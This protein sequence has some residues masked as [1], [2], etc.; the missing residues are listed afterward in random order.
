M[1]Y[2]TSVALIFLLLFAL[3]LQAQVSWN[4]RAGMTYSN[5]SYERD[6]NKANTES[7]PGVS[8]GLGVNLPIWGALSLEP[9]IQYVKRGFRAPGEGQ[10]GWGTKF[11]AR[12]SYLELPIGAV[13]SPQVGPG[14]LH[15]A[16]GPYIGYGMG[17]KWDSDGM[18]IVGDIAFEGS[19][20]LFFKNDGFE[21]GKRT[22]S[23]SYA[24]PWDYGLNLKAGY[25]F[26]KHYGLNLVFQQGLANLHQKFGDYKP[27]GSLRNK[28]FGI[29]LNYNF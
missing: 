25:T 7:I 24:K 19:G 11:K 29:E 1:N 10:I 2:K 5:I 27:D 26:M 6:G 21:G 14:K 4:I 17:G 23:Y 22:N 13:Y 20:D 28:S 3:S 18:V 9:G 8:L 16:A 12:A 15:L